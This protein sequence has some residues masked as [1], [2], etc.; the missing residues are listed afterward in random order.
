M[1]QNPTMNHDMPSGTRVNVVKDGGQVIQTT[2]RSEPWQLGH[3]AWVV[4]L[5]GT[6]GGFALERVSPVLSSEFQ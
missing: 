4:L 6:S 3:G 2:T 5:D 1:K